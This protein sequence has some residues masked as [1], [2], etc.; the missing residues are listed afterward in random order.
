[1]VCSANIVAE[2]GVFSPY[3]LECGREGRKFGVSLAKSRDDG[4]GLS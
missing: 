3:I 4:V 2:G 1:M